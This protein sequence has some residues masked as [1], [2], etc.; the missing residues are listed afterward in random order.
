LQGVPENFL[1]AAK[2]S[3]VYKL[4]VKW[5]V[6]FPPHPEF[7]TLPMVWYIPPLSPIV[8]SEGAEGAGDEIDS[9]RVPIK[10]LANLLAAGD[11]TP[12]RA[13][14]KKLVALRRYMRSVR[15]DKAPDPV[16]LDVAGMTEAM[17]EE[18]YHL[19]AI[20]KFHDRFVVPTVRREGLENLYVS[21]GGFGFPTEHYEE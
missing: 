11:E 20:A 19:L 18:M 9:M 21:R 13:A 6:A 2:L 4:A 17:A 14:L 1:E 15:V 7:R 8:R 3:P 12:V 10:Y 16:V 5:K